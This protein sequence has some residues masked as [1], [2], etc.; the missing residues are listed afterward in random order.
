MLME[1]MLGKQTAYDRVPAWMRKLQ[2][3]GLDRAA[4]GAILRYLDR[5]LHKEM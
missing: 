2:P 4:R 1:V 5:E 3:T